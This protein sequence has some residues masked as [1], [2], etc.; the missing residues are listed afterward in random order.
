MASTQE[1]TRP[2]LDRMEALLELAWPMSTP[3]DVEIVR[4]KGFQIIVPEYTA[5]EVDQGDSARAGILA[6]QLSFALVFDKLLVSQVFR[7]GVGSAVQ[8]L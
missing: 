7:L 6:S 3:R 4:R 5:E 2:Y 8:V 1:G